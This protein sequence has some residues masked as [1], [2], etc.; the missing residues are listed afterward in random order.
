MA[1]KQLLSSPSVKQLRAQG[2]SCE[3]RPLE[4]FARINRSEYPRT[5]RP[6]ND[7]FRCLSFHSPP[8]A[9]EKPYP[10]AYPVGSSFLFW[11]LETYILGTYNLGTYTLRT[12]K[13][14]PFSKHLKPKA[15]KNRRQSIQRPTR[16]QT[17]RDTGR[18]IV[19]ASFDK[20][21][22][23]SVT[24]KQGQNGPG[25]YDSREART[26]RTADFVASEL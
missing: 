26:Q 14:Q 18:D 5:G 23:C 4:C 11:T 10:V 25:P 20:A 8:I 2:S 17:V 12:Y 19:L 3:P 15:R 9:E 6:V 16:T 21:W 7:T 24:M 1:P 13:H 22:C